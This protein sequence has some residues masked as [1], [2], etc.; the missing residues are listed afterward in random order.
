[1][2]P[3]KK[4]LNENKTNMKANHDEIAYELWQ[5]AMGEVLVTV[6]HKLA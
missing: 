6:N 3:K 2:N 1:M 4:P 5:Y